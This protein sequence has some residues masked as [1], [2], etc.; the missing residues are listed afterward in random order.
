MF[1]SR[2]IGRV[3]ILQQAYFIPE[4][5]MLYLCIIFDESSDC[6]LAQSEMFS[7]LKGSFLAGPKA[8]KIMMMGDLEKSTQMTVPRWISNPSLVYQPSRHH[9]LIAMSKN[10]TSRINY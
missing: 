3:I 1:P 10:S 9:T 5:Y 4:W 7:Q 2:D 6:Q 8:G